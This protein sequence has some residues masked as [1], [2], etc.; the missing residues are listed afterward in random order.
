L[1]HFG[2][3]NASFY[4]WLNSPIVYFDSGLRDELQK[5]MPNFFQARAGTHHYLGLARQLWPSEVRE[6]I[7]GKKLLYVLR[8]TLAA[9]WILLHKSPPP[10]PFVELLPLEESRR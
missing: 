1:H 7:N 2:K 6:A 5:L 10:V 4:E 9:Q 3:S 8:A